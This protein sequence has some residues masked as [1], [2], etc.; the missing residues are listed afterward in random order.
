MTSSHH[1]CTVVTSATGAK[2]GRPAI[3]SFVSKRTGETLH[4]C[5]EHCFSMPAAV[6]P[7]PMVYRTSS[8]RPFLLV[9]LGEVVGYADTDG[10]AVQKR[11]SKLGAKVVRNVKVAR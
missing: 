5:A 7:A 9:R 10:P 6:S 11:A 8:K 1:T 4:E 2:C 3:T